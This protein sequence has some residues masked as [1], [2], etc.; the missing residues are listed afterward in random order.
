MA[1]KLDFLD[2]GLNEFPRAADWSRINNLEIPLSIN[3][4]GGGRSYKTLQLRDGEI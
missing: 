2:L 1:A 3:L 4:V